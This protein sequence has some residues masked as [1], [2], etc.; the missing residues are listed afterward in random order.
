MKPF[1][2][3]VMQPVLVQLYAVA[4]LFCVHISVISTKG[5][6]ELVGWSGVI[7]DSSFQS[8]VM[9]VWDNAEMAELFACAKIIA[10]IAS[11]GN[12]RRTFRIQSVFVVSVYG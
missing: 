5:M 9:G 1:I 4:R 12:V 10:C 8:N 3:L 7:C 6:S 2:L 11:Y